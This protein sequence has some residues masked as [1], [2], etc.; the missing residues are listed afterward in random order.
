SDGIGMAIN[1]LPFDEQEAKALVPRDDLR[2]IVNVLRRAKRLKVVFDGKGEESYSS[3][4]VFMTDLVQYRLEC[5]NY[6]FPDYRKQLP[7][8]HVAIAHID[9]VETARAINALKAI[10]AIKDYAVDLVIDENRLVLASPDEKETTIGEH[11]IP[12]ETEGTIDMRLVGSYLTTALRLCGGM[13]D[14]TA[15]K[16]YQNLMVKQNGFT[17]LLMP[18]MSNK[19]KAVYE[20]DQKAKEA[21]VPA[22][23]KGEQTTEPKS[24]KPVKTAV[25]VATKA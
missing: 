3:A 5:A 1:S 20:A 16:P 12:C 19:A 6:R 22:K 9:T 17:V 4:L 8:S 21:E 15:T 24:K 23:L 7:T 14:I 25:A 18:Q 11:V 13:V 10:N 2:A